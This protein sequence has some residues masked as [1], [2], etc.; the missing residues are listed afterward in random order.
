[1]SIARHASLEFALFVTG[2]MSCAFKNSLKAIYR[3]KPTPP[4]SRRQFHVPG[5]QRYQASEK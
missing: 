1:V 5:N 3:R 4:G 2:L